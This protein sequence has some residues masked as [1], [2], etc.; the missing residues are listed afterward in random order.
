MYVF[1]KPPKP[2]TTTTITADAP[3]PTV[4]GQSYT[5][6]F[7]VAPE[8]PGGP[9]APTGDVTVSDGTDSCSAAVT[10]GTCN[11]TSTTGGAKTL[12]ATYT[13]DSNYNGSADTEAHQVNKRDTTTT[14]TGD[15]PDPS[16]V[17]QPYA[18]TWT[19]VAANDDNLALAGRPAQ[20]DPDR[21]LARVH[22]LTLPAPTGD[23]TVS[24][25]AD[26]CTAAVVAGT[27][28]LT[29]TSAGAKTLTATYSGDAN[30]NGSA[31]TEAHTVNKANTTTT[32]TGDAPDPSFVSWPPYTVNWTVTVDAPGAGTPTGN[33]T[34]SDGANA[35]TA[36]VSAGACNLPS[37]SEGVKTLTATY[38]GDASFLTSADTEAHTV[39]LKVFGWVF[40]DSNGDGFRQISEQ[41][42]V[43]R[44]RLSLWQ[45]GGL[46]A[47]IRSVGTDGWYIFDESFL[48]GSYEL[49]AAI[50]PGYVTTSPA[51][52]SFTLQPN[53]SQLANFGVQVAPP[54][55]ATPTATETPT[56]TPTHTPTATITPTP[57]IAGPTPT[58]QQA[59]VQ[60]LVCTDANNN[61]HC[62]P[63]EAGLAGVTVQLAP[64]TGGLGVRSGR[65]TLTDAAGR[66]VFADVSPGHYTLA[67][68][69]PAGY[70]RTTPITVT[71]SPARHQTIAATFGLYWPPN[72]VYIP[73][74]LQ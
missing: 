74:L 9:A 21:W 2:A 38:A 26:S 50:P 23:V 49:R 24:D 17:G 52:V 19:V 13:G 18:V 61:G 14:I 16:V 41:T 10:V 51:Q 15:T 56:N 67:I 69:P 54:A 1:G 73:L 27:C 35:C 60:G 11:L 25:G 53:A 3:D 47:T 29:S 55:T 30:Y 63:D 70:W 57:T 48:P 34:I 72:H 42:G 37:A 45:N 22:A 44:V 68:L 40:L 8:T 46:L 71:V 65:T 66:F 64:A 58:P 59:T 31:D 62:D 39:V 5:V 33:V 7:T 6:N 32:I 12:T 4:T 36:P 43:A 28:N 20:I